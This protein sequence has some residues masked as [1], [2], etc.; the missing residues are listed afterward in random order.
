MNRACG[1]VPDVKWGE[2]A[3][4]E[5]PMHQP[6]AEVGRLRMEWG[7]PQAPNE[8]DGGGDKRPRSEAVGRLPSDAWTV[9]D[10]SPLASREKPEPRMVPV[11]KASPG[12]VV[13]KGVVGSAFVAA[14]AAEAATASTGTSGE[15]TAAEVH[16]EADNVLAASSA[17]PGADA[18]EVDRS[19]A[20]AVESRPV[21]R[22]GELRAVPHMPWLWLI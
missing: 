21:G 6:Q 10:S 7:S 19:S 8:E 14:P 18:A 9:S 16:G 1:G 5:A 3:R 22:L 17:A 11:S 15:R 4:E 13:E 2:K 20:A 12:P